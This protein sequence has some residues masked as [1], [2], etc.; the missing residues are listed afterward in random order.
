M[1]I[2]IVDRTNTVTFGSLNLSTPFLYAGKLYVK[3]SV[4]YACRV[5]S[6]IDAAIP[7]SHNCNTE[8]IASIT[9]EPK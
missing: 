9:V 3:T 6:P 1:D 8:Q 2:K 7:F 4:G 5:G